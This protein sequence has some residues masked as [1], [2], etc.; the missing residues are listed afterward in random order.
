[1]I[2]FID[3]H[4]HVHGVEPICRVLPIAPSTYRTHEARR[5]DP[6]RLSA[7]ARRDAVLCK[8][9]DRVFNE[10]FRLYGVRKVWQQ[11][12]REG[13]DVARSTVARLMKKLGLKGAVRGKP[14]RTTKS[15]Q[16]AACPLDRVN[17][18]F[19]AERPNAL[20]VA[21]FTYG[22][23]RPGWSGVHMSGMH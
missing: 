12:R 15:D 8:E 2:S 14:V 16:A 3:E 1:M 21:D 11:L 6:G 20:W 9:I 17:R 5:R 4:R 10:N 7:R 18:K 13:F 19:R 23:P 22:A